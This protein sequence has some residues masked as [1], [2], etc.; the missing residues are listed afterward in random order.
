ML[1][2]QLTFDVIADYQMIIFSLT[3]KTTTMDA[4]LFT[5]AAIDTCAEI[6]CVAQV[7]LWQLVINILMVNVSDAW[8][9]GRI[10]LPC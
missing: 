8:R 10:R 4:S 3:H 7:A 9:W 6:M 1:R 5:A 2:L